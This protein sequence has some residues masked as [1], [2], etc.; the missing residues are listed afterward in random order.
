MPVLETLPAAPVHVTPRGGTLLD[1]LVPWWDATRVESRLLDAPPDVV[2]HAALNADMI[3]AVRRH[4]VVRFLFSFRAGIERAVSFVLRRPA[5]APPAPVT[6]RLADLTS[7]GEWV[8]LA[9]DP[10]N[11]LAF[12]AIGRFWAGATRWQRIDAEEFESFERP[13]L[14]RI[15]CN[16]LLRPVPEGRTMITYEAR[17]QAIDKSARRGFSR[18]WVVV[19]P[20]VGLVMRAFLSEVERGLARR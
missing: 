12:G 7:R 3:A 11:E 5:V 14:A 18:Y 4:G 16:L 15:G 9:T 13:G 19:S 2:Y 1:H 10:P 6:L 20:M 17:T 8:I